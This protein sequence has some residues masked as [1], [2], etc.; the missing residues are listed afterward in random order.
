[1]PYFDQQREP[2]EFGRLWG[3]YSFAKLSGLRW[4]LPEWREMPCARLPTRV[5][6]N[7]VTRIWE[8]PCDC[9]NSSVK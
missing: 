6:L 5:A 8:L 7:P 2:C 1:M 4:F 3:N 9:V